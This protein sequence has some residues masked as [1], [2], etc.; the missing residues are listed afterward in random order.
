MSQSSTTV[1]EHGVMSVDYGPLHIAYDSRVLTPRD[2]TRQQSTWAADLMWTLP[3]GPMLELCSGA[4][5]IGLLAAHLSGRAAVLVDMEPTAC[6]YARLNAEA[7]GLGEIVEVRQARADVALR[8]GE[9]FACI[10]VDP[11]WVPTHEIGRFPEDPELAINGGLD[12]LDVIRDLLHVVAPALH[13]EGVA[14]V[15]LG[16]SAQV[17]ALHSWLSTD[18]SPAL[19]VTEVRVHGER[20]VVAKVEHA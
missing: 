14:L 18:A 10:L 8:A 2:W 6:H 20:G 17:E 16:T 12:G 3:A 15:Q 1:A 13:P 4:G 7:A 5:H 19:T 9:V 11:P